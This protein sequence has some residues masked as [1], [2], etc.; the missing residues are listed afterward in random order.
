MYSI[1]KLRH[2][3]PTRSIRNMQASSYAYASRPLLQAFTV[4]R[5]RR[6]H[7]YSPAASEAAGPLQDRRQP[8]GKTCAAN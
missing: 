1:A 7:Y 6:Q 2:P 3:L 5:Y 8:S 4:S